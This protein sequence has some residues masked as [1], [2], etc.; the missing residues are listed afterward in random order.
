MNEWMFLIAGSKKKK[1]KWRFD[2]GHCLYPEGHSTCWRVLQQNV[3]SGRFSGAGLHHFSAF[4]PLQV[5]KVRKPWSTFTFPTPANTFWRLRLQRLDFLVALLS[6]LLVDAPC[7]AYS[8]ACSLICWETL[9]M[10]GGVSLS[11]ATPAKNYLLLHLKSVPV[12]YLGNNSFTRWSLPWW[13]GTG[14]S[15]GPLVHAG[16]HLKTDSGSQAWCMNLAGF[17]L[18]SALHLMHLS[19]WA[20]LCVCMCVYIYSVHFCT[21]ALVCVCNMWTS[22]QKWCCWNY[23]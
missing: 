13:F 4:H 14:S 22:E 5:G 10:C 16:C 6:V 8:S 18:L 1:K 12:L 17:L 19:V 21:P 9:H 23:P 11:W 7:S 15:F 20:C 3:D 2:L